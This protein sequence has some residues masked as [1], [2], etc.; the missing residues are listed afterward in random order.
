MGGPRSSQSGTKA[1][2]RSA[3]VSRSCTRGGSEATS[4][5]QEETMGKAAVRR[6]VDAPGVRRGG[7]GVDVDLQTARVVDEELV[8]HALARAGCEEVARR[9]AIDP[10]GVVRGDPPRGVEGRRGQ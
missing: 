5:F 4:R 2:S 6:V 10:V 3:W 7:V 1:R 8:E 9:A